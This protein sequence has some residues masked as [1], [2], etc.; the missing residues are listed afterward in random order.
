VIGRQGA[1]AIAGALSLSI[2]C[3]TVTRAEEGSA[4]TTTPAGSTS[5]APASSSA[6]T[7][8]PRVAP[9]EIVVSGVRR[10]HDVNDVIISSAEGREVPGTQGDP[11]KVIESLPGMARSGF[12]S[13]ELVLWGASPSDS[14]VLVDGVEI[15]RLF[16]GSGI[17]STV[18]GDLLS[19]VTLSPGAYGAEYGRAIGGLV[20]L[21]TRELP[22][23]GPHATL[24]ASTLDGSA[25]VSA[26]A[27]DRVRVALAARYGWLDRT[28]ELVHAKDVQT[29]FAVPRYADFQGKAQ[30]ALRAGESLDLV[31]LG[32]TDELEQSVP[33]ADPALLR[34]QQ[35]KDSFERIYLH[36]RR[37]SDDGGQVEVVP[38]IGWEVART[39]AHFGSNPA[40]LDRHSFRAGLRAEHRS[41]AWK[42]ATLSLG[43]DATSDRATLTRQGSLTLPPREGDIAVFGESPGDDTNA[44]SWQTL[45]LD[46]APYVDL[47]CTFGPWSVSPSLR[48]DGYLTEASRET[49]RVGRTPAIG[50]SGF[51]GVLEPRVAIRYRL[52]RRVTLLGAAGLYSQPPAPEDLSAVFGTPTL[53]VESAAHAS[54][55]E[56]AALTDTLS[57]S[58]VAFYR[59]LRDLA[60][61]DPAP[62]PELAHALLQDGTGRSYGVQIFVR[63][64]PWHG[65]SGWISYTVSRSERRDTPGSGFRLFDYDETNLFTLVLQKTLERW[66]FGMRFR[67][68][69]GAP[70]TPVS[71]SIFDEKDDVF[72]PLFGAHN[73]VRLPDFWQLDLRVD[74]NFALGEHARLTLYLEALNVLNHANAEEYV[75]S[76]DYS[77]RGVVTGLPLLGVF[78]ARIEL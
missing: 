3:A 27:G 45:L 59:A 22:A 61:G 60:V 28:L 58:T 23:D 46:V 39:N 29:Y 68:A 53:G 31:A 16:H 73:S 42:A 52:S 66:S 38:W 1:C 64:R 65:F 4:E 41:L 9:T 2:F 74:R 51:Q 8:A 10:H 35:S 20:R 63:Q 34:E 12:G 77:K 15:P 21:E 36:Y 71:G 56:S 19:S 48:F 70:R 57:A 11:V 69:T 43:L 67:Y 25:F 50:H 49:P 17:R 7:A 14:R 26:P 37:S 40:D 44:D 76:S 47:D 30:F 33:D 24:D 55:G 5:A 78:G 18:N 32:S 62:T 13:D 75:Y 54:I 6:A 72:E